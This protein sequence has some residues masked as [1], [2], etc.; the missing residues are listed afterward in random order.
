MSAGRGDTPDLETVRRA[1]HELLVSRSPGTAPHLYKR[2][3]AEAVR[4]LFRVAASLD[5]LVLGEPQILGQ[6]KDSFELARKNGTLGPQLNRAVPRAIRAAKRVRTET[7]IGSGQV[8]VPSVAVDLSRQ[9]FGELSGK[10]ALLVG[11][12]EMAE[13]VARLLRN[14]GAQLLVIGRNQTRAAELAQACR[15][16]SAKL[17]RARSGDSRKPMS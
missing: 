13:S 14:E 1:A 10:R 17:W 2:S 15:R 6:L 8:S 5:S 16:Q 3:G 12:G 4:H 7:A 9:I 11:S